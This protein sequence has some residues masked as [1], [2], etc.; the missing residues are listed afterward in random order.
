MH[1]ARWRE[2][3]PQSFT[4][5][6]WA[7]ARPRRHELP[8]TVRVVTLNVW[9]EPRNR[10]HRTRALLAAIEGW[11]ADVVALQEVCPPVLERLLVAEMVREEYDV[12]VGDASEGYGVVLLTRLPFAAV[13]ELPLPSVMGR[14]ALAGT[15]LGA[16]GAQVAVATV[17]LESTR[18]LGAR[19]IEQL[20]RL[21]HALEGAPTALVVGDLNFDPRDPEETAR[22]PRFED[23]WA[24]LRPSEPG[25]TEDTERNALRLWTERGVAKQ[26]R[27]DR[28]LLRGSALRPQ[29]VELVGTDPFPTPNG[30][31][32]LSDHFGLMVDLIAPDERAALPDA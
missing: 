27:Y 3:R 5:V 28:A 21:G 22:D 23:V 26:A 7:P 20:E 6:R 8:R 30:P 1:A 10:E 13:H 25:Y 12:A 31:T 15:W 18:Q 19:R 4:G 9:F 32:W 24:R 17:H 29:R 16:D 11:D 14:S 2:V